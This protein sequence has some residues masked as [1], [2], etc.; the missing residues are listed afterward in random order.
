MYLLDTNT[1]INYLNADVPQYGMD[2][3]ST[4]V[5]QQCNISVV[6]KIETLGFKFKSVDDK[7]IM[8]IFINA[9]NTIPLNNDVVNQTIQL[10]KVKKIKLPDSI[11]AATALVYNLTIITR[12]IDDLKNIDDINC[13]N[14]YDL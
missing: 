3:L 12:N 7:S 9:S 13:I 6:T 2:F 11:I 4:I 1:I 10:R 5:D 8:E 14:P